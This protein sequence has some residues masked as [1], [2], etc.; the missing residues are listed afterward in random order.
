[1]QMFSQNGGRKVGLPADLKFDPSS[2]H[3]RSLCPSG[4]RVF[5]AIIGHKWALNKKDIK[6]A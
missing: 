6:I 4:S 5:L 1:M 2:A 3:P